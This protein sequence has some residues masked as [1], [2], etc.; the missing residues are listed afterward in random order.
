MTK[1]TRK[2]HIIFILVNYNRTR[3]QLESANKH[4]AAIMNF[5]ESHA[6]C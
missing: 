1:R 3:K 5:V 4:Q 6:S 2:K